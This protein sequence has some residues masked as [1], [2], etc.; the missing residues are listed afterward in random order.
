MRI[1]RTSSL[2]PLLALVSALVGAVFGCAHDV[3]NRP[4]TITSLTATPS[5]IG[6]N[7]STTVACLARD[8]NGDQLVFDWETDA[9]LTIKGNPPNEYYLYNSHSYSQVFYPGPLQI[10][11]T[12]DT[13]WVRC[14]A[15]D[16]H[17]MSDVRLI[18][19]VVNH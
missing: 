8:P 9:R 16:G 7:D 12:V 3:G 1:D 19:V 17:G 18:Y 2:I 5:S 10:H 14:F 11:P 13:A 15:R 6:P 4:P